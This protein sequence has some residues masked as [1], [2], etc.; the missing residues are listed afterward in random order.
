MITKV[1]KE[2]VGGN[3][4]QLSVVDEIRREYTNGEVLHFFVFY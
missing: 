4:R 2:F 1:K 3:S